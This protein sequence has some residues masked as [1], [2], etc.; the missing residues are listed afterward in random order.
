MLT[1]RMCR[2]K[3]GSLRSAS[4]GRCSGP[5]GVCLTCSQVALPDV[6]QTAVYSSG[7][8][9]HGVLTCGAEL[10][11]RNVRKSDGT[12]G[13]RCAG[14]P[15]GAAGFTQAIAMFGAGVCGASKLTP[16]SE[17]VRP[18]WLFVGGLFAKVE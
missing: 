16:A 6:L 12:Y 8:D 17:V 2:P 18:N 10:P 3:D 11:P 13:S 14:P 15:P 9:T 5:P 1:S 7:N 4:S